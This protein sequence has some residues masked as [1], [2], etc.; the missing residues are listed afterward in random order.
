MKKRFIL[1]ACYTIIII[2]GTILSVVIFFCPFYFMYK[3]NGLYLLLFFVS[4]IPAVVCFG[5]SYLLCEFIE[6]IG[7]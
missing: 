3:D 1:D 2:V 6:E 5:I 4:W 7:K